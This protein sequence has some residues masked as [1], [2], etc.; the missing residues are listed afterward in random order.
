MQGRALGMLCAGD[1]VALGWLLVADRRDV[2]Y[3]VCCLG[4]SVEFGGYD[5]F[6]DELYVVPNRRRRGFARRALGHAIAELAARGVR[7]VHL[8]VERGLVH[9]QALYRQTGFVGDER[10]LLTKRIAGT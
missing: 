6:I 8:Q 7:A 4:F 10:F 2:G 5:S 9:A 3:I 1:P